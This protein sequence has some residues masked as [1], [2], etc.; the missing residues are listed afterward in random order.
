MIGIDGVFRWH[1]HWQTTGLDGP[2]MATA[3]SILSWDLILCFGGVSQRHWCWHLCCVVDVAAR[4][5]LT[6]YNDCVL[7]VPS[8][9]LFAFMVPSEMADDGSRVIKRK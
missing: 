6:T 8:K 7:N 1:L 3:Y 2:A 4:L 5:Y 9:F